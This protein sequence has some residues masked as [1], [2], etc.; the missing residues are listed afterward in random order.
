ML[1]MPAVF[2]G[3]FIGVFLGTYLEGE[4]GELIKMCLFGITVAWSIYTTIGKA[5]E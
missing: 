5:K 4:R 1:T 2:M 3:S